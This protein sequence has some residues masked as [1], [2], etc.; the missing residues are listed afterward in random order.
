MP[1]TAGGLRSP[2][3]PIWPRLSHVTRVSDAVHL[4][5]QT[6]EPGQD[7]DQTSTLPVGRYTVVR[8]GQ[9]RLYVPNAAFLTRE[10]LVVDDPEADERKRSL[11]GP[12]MA[13]SPHAYVQGPD[14]HPRW[15]PVQ[16]F[17]GYSHYMVDPRC[18]R[19]PLC[20]CRYEL[21]HHRSPDRA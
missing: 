6:S 11:E 12:V 5:N 16:P 19:W 15:M 7:Q 20:A 8:S 2:H 18:V 1:H 4:L 10:F 14:G 3:N 17:D 13:P 21:W 9:R